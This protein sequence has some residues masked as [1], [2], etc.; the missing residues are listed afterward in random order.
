MIGKTP[1]ERPVDSSAAWNA[2]GALLNRAG[3]V[4]PNAD[5]TRKLKDLAAR[6]TQRRAWARARELDAD[7]KLDEALAFAGQA[8]KA[9]SP[10]DALSDYAAS[11]RRRRDEQLADAEARRRRYR[12]LV[13]KARA[14]AEPSAAEELWTRAVELASTD[15]ERAAARSG[16]AVA[17]KAKAAV[18]SRAAADAAFA[19]AMRDG[20]NS[21]AD[22]QPE[23]AI[24]RF[25]EALKL[26]P[27][28]PSAREALDRAD[29]ARLE[30]LYRTAMAAFEEAEKKR[31]F[32]E[33]KIQFAQALAAKPG[34][35]AA[36]K[37]ARELESEVKK[38]RLVLKLDAKAGMEFVL[39]KAGTFTMGS[40]SGDENARPF[41]AVISREIWMLSTEV[42]QEQWK[43][44]MGGNPSV[45]PGP[46]HAVNNVSWEDAQA[47]VRKFNTS[48]K[49][50]RASLPT[51]AEWE[52]AWRAGT[53]GDYWFGEWTAEKAAKYYWHEG[54]SELKHHPVAQKTPNPWGLYDL[55]GSLWE[56]CQDW[57][58]APYPASKTVDP[59][60]PSSG[61]QRTLRGGS[62]N[63]HPGDAKSWRRNRTNVNHHAHDVGF[64]IILR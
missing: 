58:G 22:G 8:I 4:S 43:L 38:S 44:V 20:E 47:F 18:E 36:Q 14:E 53:S 54:N 51:E 27:G 10:P 55:G 5:E 17:L 32:Q 60:G 15:D 28:D 7:G 56:W 64:R 23:E 19:A 6:V 41:E 33:A 16:L 34:D 42:S 29:R 50:N 31:S 40:E 25:N 52:Y 57:G 30:L 24:A 11:L 59:A 12:E 62:K 9:A 48:M 21:P 37:A 35:R 3:A 13:V 39:V 61:D 46:G 49:F 1:P 45:E 63:H 26:R 2:A